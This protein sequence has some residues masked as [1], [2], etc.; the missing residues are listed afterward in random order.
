[1]D[2]LLAPFKWRHLI[3]SMAIFSSKSPFM[4]SGSF[5]DPMAPIDPVASLTTMATVAKIAMML[6]GENGAK[7]N[8]DGCYG[9]NGANGDCDQDRHWHHSQES[10]SIVAIKYL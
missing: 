9:D 4:V 7:F 5:G 10:G 3:H 1:M 2:V 6:V 8:H